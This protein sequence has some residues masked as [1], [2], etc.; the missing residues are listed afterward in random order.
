LLQKPYTEQRAHLLV[1][2]GGLG[3][4]VFAFPHRTF[5]EYL[6][7][8]YL[9]P[10]MRLLKEAPRLAEAGDTWR[11]VLNLAAGALV[12]NNNNYEQVLF[13]VERMMPQSPPEMSHDP[14]WYRVW[15]GGEMAAVVGRQNFEESDFA[16]ELLPRLRQLLAALLANEALTPLQRA[17]AG[18]ALGKLGDPRPGV[19]TLEPD[20]I[21]IPAGSFLYGDE[22]ERRTIERPY[23]IARYPV[24]VAQFEMFMEAGGY[25]EPRYWGGEESAGW[26]WR[27]SEHNTE[28]RGEGPVTQPEY[29]LQPRWHGDNRP[30]VGVS[31]YEAQAYCAWLTEQSGRE[32]R[33]PTEKEW[34]R[35]A[36]HT[37]G[38]KWVWGDN[39]Q[40]GIIN[41]EEA[42]IN[43]TTAV[44][45]FPHGAAACGAQDLSGNVWEWPASFY[46]DDKDRYNVRGGSWSNYP[47]GARV[48]SRFGYPAG[49]SNPNLGF[50]LVSPVF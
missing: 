8:C 49:Y 40:D 19:R 39:W 44:G 3:E 24:T 48:A 16:A 42:G 31:W 14:A 11:E 15:L 35:A 46:D 25:E 26:R 28:W 33:L 30:I 41:T 32:Y 43:K 13:A 36:R 2:R 27:V 7:A 47:D 37:D 9:T 18:D 17:E 23:A 29:W 5:Q 10:G 34:E 6:A 50:R 38:R 45:A 22:K 12:Y 4:R 20:L 21:E 1:G